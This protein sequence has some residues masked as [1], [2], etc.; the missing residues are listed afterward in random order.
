MRAN[1]VGVWQVVSFPP[2]PAQVL[3]LRPQP[4]ILPLL[5]KVDVEDGSGVQVG[6]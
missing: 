5:P 2:T 3:N 1:S 6:F 4:P